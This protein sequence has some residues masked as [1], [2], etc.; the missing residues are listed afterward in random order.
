[1]TL[2]LVTVTVMGFLLYHRFKL[3]SDKSAVENTEMTVERTID[4]LNS[5]LLDLRQISDAA[6]YNIVQEY[7]ISSQEFAKQCSLLYETNSDKIQSMALYGS[8]GNLIASEPVSLEKENVEIKNQDWYQNAENA[9]EN[10]HFS[11]SSRNK[12]RY[13]YKLP[14]P[15]QGSKK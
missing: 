12:S 13:T 4:R 6:N 15:R 2:S 3:A 1:M 14:L 7:D 8:D 9:I 10:I 11:P 5:S